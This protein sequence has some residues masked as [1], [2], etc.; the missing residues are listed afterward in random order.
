MEPTGSTSPRESR[1][2]ILH[3]YRELTRVVTRGVIFLK[4][5]ERTC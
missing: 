3:A 2:A 5:F 4:A 1:G